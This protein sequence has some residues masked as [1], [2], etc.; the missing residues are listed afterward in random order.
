[1]GFA[2]TPTSGRPKRVGPKCIVGMCWDL[3]GGP[4]VAF[5]LPTPGWESGW[6]QPCP[7]QPLDVALQPRR[8]R[9]RP[10]VGHDVRPSGPCLVMGD[11]GGQ[12]SSPRPGW[13]STREGSLPPY[14][15]VLGT[16]GCV[17]LSPSQ[18]MRV[19]HLPLPPHKENFD[20]K[21]WRKGKGVACPPPQ[22]A[23]PKRLPACPLLWHAVS[24]FFL[25]KNPRK[26]EEVGDPHP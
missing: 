16:A 4:G 17:R 5:P 11:G 2:G 25:P 10:Q 21:P 8:K 1:M 20:L 13:P 19:Q 15:T 14:G 18:R 26:W 12:S 6:G 9:V 24:N 23:K 22:D 7:Q 3:S